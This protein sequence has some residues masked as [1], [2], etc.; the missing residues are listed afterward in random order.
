MKEFE[1]DEYNEQ[2]RDNGSYT[3]LI[4][5]D[6]KGL[7]KLISKHIK[8]EGLNIV[9]VYSGREALE[10]I[11]MGWILLLDYKLPDMTAMELI[12]RLYERSWE[13]IFL[14][15]TGRG[16][17]K[18]A[19]DFMKKGAFDYIVKDINL[20]EA[21][22][23]KI[24][25]ACNIIDQQ[26][27]LAG[28]EKRR[29]KAEAEISRLASFPENNPHPVIQIAI[30]GKILYLNPATKKIFP[31]ILEKDIDHPFFKDIGKIFNKLK[32]EGGRGL[33][34]RE[35]QVGKEWYHQTFVYLAKTECVY[36]YSLNI[37]SL[38]KT[39]ERLISSL[40]EKEVLLRELYHRTKNNMQVIS[41]MLNLYSKDKTNRKIEDVF[42]DIEM[43][44]ASMAY[45]HQKLY[46]S[47]D[48]SHLNL[49]D[50]IAGLISLII[51][52]YNAAENINFT[53]K[54][55]DL[56]VLIDT[57]APLGLVVNELIV[58][59]LKHAFP[60]NQKGKICIEQFVTD[61]NQLVIKIKDNGVGLEKDFDLE[62][63]SGLGLETVIDIVKDQLLGRIEYTNRKGLTWHIEL[64]KEQYKQRI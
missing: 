6:D 31:D 4:A 27:A 44:I 13:G 42:K 43:K 14:I 45:V 40:G 33:V 22:P 16:D 50:Y 8:T 54:G 2:N 59:S 23:R 17:E 52:S 51:Q 21:L 47:N 7:N 3:A 10:K 28:S 63:S 55:V 39:Q 26:R 62:K 11:S 9:S 64:D 18:I 37:S 61:K 29:I 25:Q 38:K 12:D 48:L 58:N 35:M 32:K 30:S 34:A 46:E 41:S 36:I 60:N 1:K 49:K 15:I 24:K 56:D 19:V 20:I 5:E 53:F 57:A